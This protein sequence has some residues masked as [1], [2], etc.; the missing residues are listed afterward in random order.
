LRSTTSFGQPAV[1][2]WSTSSSIS[3]T[4]ATRK[5]VRR[6]GDRVGRTEV[7]EVFQNDT[8]Q[9]LEGR[10][11]FPLPADASISRLALWVND[12]PV[13]GE[14]VEKK[15]AAAIFKGIVEDTVRPRDPALLEWVSGGDFSLKIFPLP[16][17]GSRKVRIAYDQALA[18]SGG[19]VRY[20]YPL[21]VGS[22]RAIEIDD[23]S[24]QVRAAD[25]RSKLEEVET[26][27]YA[28]SKTGDDRGFR[29]GFS[30]RRFTP[31]ADFIVSYARQRAD[32]A[33]VSAY[34]PAW[35]EFKG[36]GLDDAARGAEGTG[37]FALR[38]RADLPAGLTPA[39]TR[40][41]RAIVV[42][43]SHSQSKETLDGEA[44]LA[45]GLVS[46]LDSDERFVVLACDSACVTFPDSGL[47]P[48][49]DQNVAE[50][51][52]W[53]AARSPTGSSDVAGAL[54]DAARRLEPTN[55]GQIVYIGDG[56]PTSGEL[57]ASSVTVRVR[58]TLAERKADL[59]FLGAGRVVRDRHAA[60]PRPG[61][62][63]SRS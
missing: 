26:P 16:P 61:G 52:R 36:G 47:A 25:T 62:A 8:S 18:E 17:K 53:L 6:G 56:S 7:E 30:A 19:R 21:S 28:T 63:T 33:E 49:T 34:V 27:G 32:E 9:V 41:D 3:L 57:S 46:Q 39:H 42:D 40:R 15:R 2:T 48:P 58:S 22:E 20:V 11:V 59:R 45:A 14:I 31:L 24:V 35:G 55:A 13:E 50:L 12:K 23:F 29:A 54:L 37:Y 10:Y 5:S 44:K 4:A 60:P 51:T 38:V 1:W 43:A